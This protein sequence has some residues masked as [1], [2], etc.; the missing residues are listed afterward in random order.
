MPIQVCG[1]VV[2]A[3][4]GTELSRV[5]TEYR[6]RLPEPIDKSP[7]ESRGRRCYAIMWS[8]RRNDIRRPIQISYATP[9]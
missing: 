5:R 7:L 8:T 6:L 2:H 3:M 9:S 1:V 4:S